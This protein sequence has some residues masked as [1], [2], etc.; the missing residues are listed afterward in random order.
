VRVPH[1]Q[2]VT[3]ASFHRTVTYAPKSFVRVEAVKAMAQGTRATSA[4]MNSAMTAFRAMTNVVGAIPLSA[5]V[6]IAL[7]TV[8]LA[9]NIIVDPVESAANGVAPA[10]TKDASVTTRSLRRNGPNLPKEMNRR[11]GV[12]LITYCR[13]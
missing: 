1:I 5:R 10:V 3:I 6:I 13:F 12:S 8:E 7:F 2:P 4:K 9:M 11:T